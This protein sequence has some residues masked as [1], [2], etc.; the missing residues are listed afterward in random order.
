MGLFSKSKPDPNTEIKVLNDS[1]Q[2]FFRW[3]EHGENELP[4]MMSFDETYAKAQP[5]DYKYGVEFSVFVPNDA[6]HIFPE[7]SM[8]QGHV[9][10]NFMENEPQLYANIEAAKSHSKLIAKLTGIG[11]KV[12]RFQTREPKELIPILEKW[13]TG[14]QFVRRTEVETRKDW[15]YYTGILPNLAERQQISDRFVIEHAIQNGANREDS[16]ACDFEFRGD[17]NQLAIIQKDLEE[18]EFTTVKMDG[19]ALTLQR[20]LPLDLKTISHFTSYMLMSAMAHNCSFDGW[21]CKIG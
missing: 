19:N 11:R 20:N 8:I 9:N 10:K 12:Y 17:A 5:K 16:Y 14:L 1:W 3:M 18:E 2:M 6:D 4:I 7:T 13:S 21:G 15:T